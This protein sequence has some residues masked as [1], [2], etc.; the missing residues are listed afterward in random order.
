MSKMSWFYKK[1]YK[2]LEIILFWTKKKKQSLLDLDYKLTPQIILVEP[3]RLHVQSKKKP[4]LV[5]VSAL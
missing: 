2:K 3:D 5:Q 1:K 4:G